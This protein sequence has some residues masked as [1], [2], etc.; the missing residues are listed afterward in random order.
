MSERVKET[1]AT[2]GA[3]AGIVLLMLIRLRT[4]PDFLWRDDLQ[5]GL[6]G[7][8]LEIGRA[9]SE[10]EWPLLSRNSWYATAFAGEMQYAVFSPLI[11]ALNWLVFQLDL[12]LRATTSLLI[13]FH[14]ALLAAGVYLLARDYKLPRPL[15][16]LVVLVASLNGY[17]LMWVATA[18]YPL[19]TSFAWLPFYWLA[20]RRA[21][22]DPRALLPLAGIAA[23]LYMLLAAGW[24]GT[25]MMAIIL[26]AAFAMQLLARKEF[27]ALIRIVVANAIGSALCAPQLLVMAEFVAHTNRTEMQLFNWGWRVPLAGLPG[28]ILPTFTTFWP[29]AAG[30][31]RVHTGIELAGAVVPL[32]AI[33]AALF[34]FG[35]AFLQRHKFELA[36]AL[37]GI[38]LSIAPSI[39]M[40]KWSF[41]WLPLF[42][43]PAAL[44][45]AAALAELSQVRTRGA[46]LWMIGLTVIA[47]IASVLYDRVRAISLVVAAVTLLLAVLWLVVDLR[48]TR[49]AREVVPLLVALVALA[50]AYAF[51]PENARSPQFLIGEY[52]KEP[53]PYKRDRTYIAVYPMLDLAA[54]IRFFEPRHKDNS[55]FRPGN[56]PMAADLDFVGGYSPL[57]PWGMVHV[58]GYEQIHGLINEDA[59]RRIVLRE[60]GAEG[61]L[62]HMSVEGV[63]VT[64]NLLVRSQVQNLPGWRLAATWGKDVVLERRTPP[65]PDVYFAPATRAFPTREAAAEWIRTRTEAR[66]PWVVVGDRAP[67][68]CADAR[69]GAS[70]RLRHESVAQVDTRRCRAEALLVFARPWVPGFVASLNGETLAVETADLIMPAVR[71]PAGSAGEV[72]LAYEP[73]SLVTGAIVAA[74]ALLAAVVLAIMRV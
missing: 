29:H 70:Q 69:V 9:L 52:P 50:L 17:M 54:P 26:V 38:T 63:A 39:Y 60:M 14:L 25:N 45:A 35:R 24:P 43:L 62:D 74:V 61:L 8:A 71:V 12:P 5:T 10:G 46:G 44:A 41:R 31:P 36:L 16:G 13:V 11:L 49:E 68:G 64:Q 30:D 18:W 19:L 4:D 37:L 15:C 51:V 34:T 7:S 33:A 23:S 66:M 21:V 40:F 1:L 2:L 3:A 72:R 65:R 42:F 6:I 53:H 59:A 22:R 56:L 73:R 28:L 57:S 27:R 58:L 32:A 47:S 55:L 48:G 20:T 67:A